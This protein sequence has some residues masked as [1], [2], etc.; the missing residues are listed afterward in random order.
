[1][2]WKT[3]CISF[4]EG[5]LGLRSLQSINDAAMLKLCWKFI[6]SDLQWARLARARFFKNRSHVAYHVR[7][8][9]WTGIKPFHQ[10]V[11]NNSS[12]NGKSINFWRD[13][14]LDQAIVDSFNVPIEVQRKLKASV[15]DFIK[16]KS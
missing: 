1:M 5:G 9:I 12:C 4:E 6:S 13:N 7:S 2:A 8:S 15:A 3:I 11:L 16:E 10:T 14:W